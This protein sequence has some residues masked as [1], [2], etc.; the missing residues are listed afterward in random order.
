MIQELHD[1]YPVDISYD[2]P[3]VTT[4]TLV[5]LR[6]GNNHTVTA[7]ERD[8]QLFALWNCTELNWTELSWEQVPLKYSPSHS[9]WDSS[10]IDHY[11]TMG[12]LLLMSHE[13]LYLNDWSLSLSIFGTNT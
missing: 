6:C 7:I 10:L 8:Q 5:D 1:L 11:R 13:R 3:Q 9:T 4:R 12:H 2:D